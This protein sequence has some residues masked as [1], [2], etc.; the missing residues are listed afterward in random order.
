LKAV[1][2][3]DTVAGKGHAIPTRQNIV[4]FHTDGTR[5]VPGMLLPSVARAG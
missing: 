5:L 3:R 4:H 2:A 1:G